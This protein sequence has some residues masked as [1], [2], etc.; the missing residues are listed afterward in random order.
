MNSELQNQLVAK[1][2]SIF[3]E[4]GIENKTA[5]SSCISW[6]GIE[7]GDGWFNLID[8]LC[9]AMQSEAD[10]VNRLYPRMK[11]AV[12]AAQVKEKYGSLRFYADFVYDYAI[13]SDSDSYILRKHINHINGMISFAEKLSMTTCENCE[14]R[15]NP[16][17][18]VFPRA[19]CDGCT[20]KREDALDGIAAIDEEIAEADHNNAEFRRNGGK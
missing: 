12:V 4:F 19:Q 5:A 20:K 2:P 18:S 10:Y 16:A 3:R 8:N 15:C 7:C 17:T 11:F 13:D 1:Y 14:A 9:D 6:F